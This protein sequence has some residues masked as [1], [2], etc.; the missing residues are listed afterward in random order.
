[1]SPCVI[2]RLRSVLNQERP[3]AAVAPS[4]GST[5][6]EV[7]PVGPGQA[8]VV[9]AGSK[10]GGGGTN[11]SVSYTSKKG[12]ETPPGRERKLRDVNNVMR[13]TQGGPPGSGVGGSAAARAREQKSPYQGHAAGSLGEVLDVP[14][15]MSESD[16]GASNKARTSEVRRGGRTLAWRLPLL[17]G[18]NNALLLSISFRGFVSSY[19]D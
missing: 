11:T 2:A 8:A 10:G 14:S 19:V 4:H 6:A 5:A 3:S 18:D 1:M 7:P 15:V 12:Y 17:G 13:R 16:G 9:A